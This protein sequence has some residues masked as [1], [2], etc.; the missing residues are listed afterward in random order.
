MKTKEELTAEEEIPEE[1][2][3]EDPEAEV[4][5]DPELINAEAGVEDEEPE[6][7]CLPGQGRDAAL[8]AIRN[9]KPVVARLP[10]SQRKKAADSLAMLIRGQLGN[11]AQ[12]GNLVEAKRASKPAKDSTISDEELGRYIRDKYNS[13]YRK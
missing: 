9:L 1:T 11:D 5:A 12:Y 8:Q 7:G 6:A 13:H 2:E 3:D 4:E 10:E